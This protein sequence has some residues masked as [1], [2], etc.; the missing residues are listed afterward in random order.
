MAKRLAALGMAAAIGVGG[1]AVAAVDP[2]TVAGAQGTGAPAGAGEAG[3]SGASGAAR[4][5]GAL[6]RALDGL[7]ADGTLTQAQADEVMAAAKAEAGAGR[8]RRR[9]RRD[10]LLEVAA[11]ALGSTPDDVKAGVAAGTSIAEQAEAKGI[12]R[13]VVDDALTKAATDRIDAAVADGTLTEAQGAKA[14]ERVDK[15]VDRI[16]DADG[17]GRS[18]GRRRRSGN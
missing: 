17:S 10:E 3:A 2:L 5:A 12:D 7:V 1:L 4:R 11:E 13:Q 6:R 18:S 15:A 14:T 8:Q 9:E 16:L